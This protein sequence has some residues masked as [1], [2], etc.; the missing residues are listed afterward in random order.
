MKRIIVT[1]LI[2]C[3]VLSLGACGDK[4]KKKEKAKVEDLS[5][6][7]DT[8]S[9]A[10]TKAEATATTTV[11]TTSVTTTKAPAATKAPTTTKKPVAPVK[12]VYEIKNGVYYN[13]D[14]RISF[15]V[16]SDWDANSQEG[17]YV[18][19]NEANKYNADSAINII[20]YDQVYKD[21]PMLKWYW[22]CQNEESIAKKF[23]THDA[24]FTFES[25]KVGPFEAR[26]CVEK[27][28]QENVHGTLYIVWS[29]K[30]FVMLVAAT[31]A[32]KAEVINKVIGGFRII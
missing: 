26:Y 6:I 15:N 17:L 25:T 13:Y 4:G 3:M 1:L 28:S 14:L 16:M 2:V 31:P 20:T 10:E 19:Y 23:F 8:S 18:L 12:K 27:N 11:T 32:K 21:D 5:S 7:E 30:P 22:L 24:T 29:D 9:A